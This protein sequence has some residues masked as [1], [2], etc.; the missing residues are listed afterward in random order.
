MNS[1]TRRQ[2]CGMPISETFGNLGTNADGF[3]VAEFCV[4]CFARVGFTN[5]QQTP[6]KVIAG[7]VENMI[8]DLQ[9]PFEQ[10]SALANS[11]IPKLKRRQ[12]KSLFHNQ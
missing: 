3:H 5:P 7:S 8:G 1:K 6:A 10:A 12:N 4:F 11:F 9:T 2:S